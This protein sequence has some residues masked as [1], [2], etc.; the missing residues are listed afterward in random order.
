[1]F[2]ARCP[3]TDA[4]CARRASTTSA[5]TSCSP[6]TLTARPRP[7]SRPD[8]PV[9]SGR[10]RHPHA[11]RRGRGGR[12]G[13]AHQLQPEPPRR[14]PF[15][16]PQALYNEGGFDAHHERHQGEGRAARV[17]RRQRQLRAR[18]RRLH[19][20]RTDF[21]NAR[22]FGQGRRRRPANMSAPWSPRCWRTAPAWC[23]STSR[24]TAATSTPTPASRSTS[25]RSTP[26]AR[27]ISCPSRP[28]SHAGAQSVLVSHNVVNCMDSE[29]PASLSPAVH[30]ILRDGAGL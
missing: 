30:D 23:S 25:A 19:Q 18:V 29:L 11:D 7:A 20:S 15:R 12:H 3:E 4:A 24:A 21:I 22:A 28:A 1:M 16:S 13:R 6:A 8:H 14:V 10:G 2:F 5:A 17:P 26:S 27:A 9:L